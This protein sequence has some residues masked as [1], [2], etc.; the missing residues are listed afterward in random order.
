MSTMSRGDYNCSAIATKSFAELRMSERERQRAKERESV[1]R[2][3][4]GD[5]ER[6]EKCNNDQCRQC[7]KEIET[8]VQ[9]LG[10]D[11]SA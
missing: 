6:K 11:F 10:K 7:L 2:E 8:A 5:R 3:R 4:G 1:R 9:S